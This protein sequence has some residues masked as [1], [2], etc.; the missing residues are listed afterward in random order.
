MLPNAFIN[1]PKKPTDDELTEALGP[2]KALWDKLITDLSDELNLVEKEWNS[3]S[4]KAG[5]SMRLKLKK[6]NIVYLSPCCGCFFV[7]FVLGDKAAQAAHQ[8]KLPRQV[9]KTIDEAIRY[10]EGTAVRIV[11]K[12]SKDIEIAKKLAAIK[13][14]N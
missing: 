13:L 5:W 11:I 4:L 1:K 2:A 7:A 8:S 9:I 14:A 6:R 10:P 3:Y 12:G